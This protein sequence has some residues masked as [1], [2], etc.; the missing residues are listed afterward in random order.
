MLDKQ[1]A[2]WHLC[3]EQGFKKTKQVLCDNPENPAV[4]VASWWLNPVFAAVHTMS[5]ARVL[6]V[7]CLRD[8]GALAAYILFC[9]CA[10]L[11]WDLGC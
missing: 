8:E 1:V 5:L 3:S 2:Q 4:L 11:K 6:P 7:R 9:L 10:M